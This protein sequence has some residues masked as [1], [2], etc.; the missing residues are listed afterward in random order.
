M[1]STHIVTGGAGFVGSNLVAALLKRQRDD[2]VVVVD[3]FRTGSFANIVS[4]CE[5][6]GAGPFRGRVVPESTASANW[7]ELIERTE[8]EAIFHLGAITDT[9]LA[10]EREMIHENVHG[11]GAMLRAAADAGSCQSVV[12]ASS[13]ATYGTPEHAARRA[14]FPL[15]AAGRPSNVYGFS[16]WLMECEHARFLKEANIEWGEVGGYASPFLHVVGLRYFNVFGPGEARKGKMASMCLQLATQMLEGRRPRLFTDGTQARDQ[17]YV[18][19]VVDGTLAAAGFGAKREVRGGVYNLGSGVATS[20]NDV[21][22][23]LRGALD[24][25]ESRLPTEYF[26][27]PASVRAFYQ[28]FTLA[29]MTETRAGL[30]WQ[31][32]WAPTE[33]IAAY[34]RWL[35]GRADEVRRHGIADA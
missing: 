1:G 28:D 26:E 19:D 6:A 34:G 31:P 10:G 5:R 11:F 8:P 25:P 7:P 21:V 35:K 24:I 16:K 2:A 9:T 29:D 30:A 13:A 22:A 20:F 27:M 14:A 32:R 3:N 23:A 12:Y 33:A 15:H 4:A 17:V 18:D